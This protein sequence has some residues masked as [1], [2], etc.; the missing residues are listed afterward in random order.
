[1]ARHLSTLHIMTTFKQFR[2]SAVFGLANSMFAVLFALYALMSILH[3]DAT[4]EHSKGEWCLG[5]FAILVDPKGVMEAFMSPMEYFI[6]QFRYGIDYLL[7]TCWMLTALVFNRFTLPLLAPRVWGWTSG[8]F[9]RM[10]ILA[11]PSMVVVQMLMALHP[12]QF[13]PLQFSSLIPTFHVNIGQVFVWVVVITPQIYLLSLTISIIR[14]KAAGI[15]WGEKM[16]RLMLQ[17]EN[18]KGI[19]R[20]FLE[21]S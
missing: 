12:S 2:W 13:V 3:L 11:V 8:S 20:V 21:K 5:L 9:L 16:M 15:H 10:G 18:T 7:I 19:R 14:Y 1:M 6:D 4:N 17:E